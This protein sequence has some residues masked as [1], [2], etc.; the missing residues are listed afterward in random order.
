[1]PSGFCRAVAGQRI[2]EKSVC[3]AW[4]CFRSLSIVEI[5]LRLGGMDW[6]MLDFSA[7][8]LAAAAQGAP[9]D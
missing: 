8:V 5:P 3:P 4:L 2:V 6:R 9:G 7:V 1:M